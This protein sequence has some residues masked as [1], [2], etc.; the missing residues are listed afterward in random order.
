MGT[1]CKGIYETIKVEQLTKKNK[2]G[3]QETK[4]VRIGIR[5]KK[6]S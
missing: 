2:K 6:R 5:R 3:E 4:T 1:S